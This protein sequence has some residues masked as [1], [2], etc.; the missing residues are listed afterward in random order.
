MKRMFLICLFQLM[1]V[2]PA[3]AQEDEQLNKDFVGAVQ[4]IRTERS[5]LLIK[6]GKPNEGKKVLSSIYTYDPTGKL[7]ESEI[8]KPDGVLFKKYKASYDVS[9]NKREEI[10]FEPKGSIDAKFI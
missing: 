10:Y 9:T 2:A 6:D 4:T 5:N 3:L 1:L 7:S 8:Y